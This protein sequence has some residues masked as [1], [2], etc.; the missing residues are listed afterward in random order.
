M[1]HKA[2][3]ELTVAPSSANVDKANVGDF[4]SWDNELYVCTNETIGSAVFVKQPTNT[5]I[6]NLQDQIQQLA[7]T[8]LTQNI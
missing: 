6:I 5:D 2:I 7:Y 3:G 1:K 4:V 8:N